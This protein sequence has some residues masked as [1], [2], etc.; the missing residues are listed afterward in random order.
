MREE[1]DLAVT[2]LKDNKSLGMDI[3]AELIKAT[4]YHT[5]NAVIRSMQYLKNWRS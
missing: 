1:F 4:G 3:P 5:M 2:K